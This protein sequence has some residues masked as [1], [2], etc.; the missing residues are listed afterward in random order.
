MR[1]NAFYVFSDII[2]DLVFAQELVDPLHEISFDF[3]NFS[4]DRKN[5]RIVKLLITRGESNANYNHLNPNSVKIR[6]RYTL[7]LNLE[8]E[9]TNECL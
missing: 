7:E 8:I 5:E 9:Q 2:I 6:M 4:N 1:F 3:S